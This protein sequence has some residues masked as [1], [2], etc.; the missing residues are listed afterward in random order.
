MCVTGPLL[1]DLKGLSWIHL[2]RGRVIESFKNDTKLIKSLHCKPVERFLD[3]SDVLKPLGFSQKPSCCV[4]GHLKFIKWMFLV[5]RKE[6]STGII[7]Y[8]K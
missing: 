8:W 6:C 5:F 7:I 4:L 2:G 1:E 3:W